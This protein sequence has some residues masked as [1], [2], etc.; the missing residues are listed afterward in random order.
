MLK[1]AH[2][3]AGIAVVVVSHQEAFVRLKDE[4]ETLNKAF[5]EPKQDS[6]TQYTTTQLAD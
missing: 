1:V 6:D 5:L 2:K 3:E 4:K